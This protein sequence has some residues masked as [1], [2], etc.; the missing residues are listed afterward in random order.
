LAVLVR[1]AWLAIPGVPA[2]AELTMLVDDK[3]EKVEVDKV[4]VIDDESRDRQALKTLEHLRRRAV[5]EEVPRSRTSGQ[6]RGRDW[7]SNLE[8]ERASKRQRQRPSAVLLD[9]GRSTI[10]S[11]ATSLVNARRIMLMTANMA[12]QPGPYLRNRRGGCAGAQA[13][14]TR[15]L[16]LGGQSGHMAC[17]STDFLDLKRLSIYPGPEMRTAR[18]ESAAVMLDSTRMMVIGGRQGRHWL[19]STEVINVVTQEVRPGPY[20]NFNR[21]SAAV[22]MIGTS[23]LM[24]LGGKNAY[25]CIDTTEILNIHRAPWKF[26]N[27]P[28]LRKKRAGATVAMIDNRKL[29]VI[30]G[31][32]GSKTH[33]TTEILHLTDTGGIVPTMGPFVVTPRSY[34]ASL[35]LNPGHL[36]IIGGRDGV[37]TLNT[38]EVLRLSNME[39]T[40]GPM[41]QAGRSMCTAAMSDDGRVVVAGGTDG[42]GEHYSTEVLS[43]PQ[44]SFP[45]GPWLDI[46]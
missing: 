36:F 4:H 34:S 41:M 20:L 12:F 3:E 10:N 30:G 15:M 26:E 22:A 45:I 7:L 31:T 5:L 44:Y 25:G 40:N 35:M 19:D 46:L 16:V 17:R 13:D 24:V 6:K 23:H 32:D 39:F 1:K 8:D 43:L 2:A 33:D 27:G 9:T 18:F 38:T 29:L 37:K 42:A 21:A 14:A 11:T 28:K